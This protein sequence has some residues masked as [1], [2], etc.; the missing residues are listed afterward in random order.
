[1]RDSNSISFLLSYLNG[2]LALFIPV[3]LLLLYL[4]YF[5]FDRVESKAI[6]LIGEPSLT[7]THDPLSLCMQG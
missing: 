2:I 7:L 5:S 4:G 6:Y 1:M 3:G